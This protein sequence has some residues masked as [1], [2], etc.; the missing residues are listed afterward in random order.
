[1]P[2]LRTLPQ[3]MSKKN[4]G[5]QLATLGDLPGLTTLISSLK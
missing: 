1:M 3:K 5:N 2:L 4:L